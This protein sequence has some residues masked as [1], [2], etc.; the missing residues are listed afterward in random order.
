VPASYCV[1][2]SF[3][4]STDELR[5]FLLCLIAYLSALVAP[6]NWAFPSLQ[7][8]SLR[9]VESP[10][11]GKAVTCN[12]GDVVYVMLCFSFKGSH[13]KIEIRPSKRVII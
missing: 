3:G 12:F 6:V 1:S 13:E 5:S 4:S 7:K 8:L 2:C 9:L 10:A 11:S